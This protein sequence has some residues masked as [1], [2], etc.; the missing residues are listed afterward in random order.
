MLLP[1]NVG[2]PAAMV[3]QAMAVY[4]QLGGSRGPGG[5]KASEEQVGP[6][7]EAANRVSGA[8][9]AVASS[10]PARPDPEDDDPISETPLHSN[11]KLSKDEGF[12]L[13]QR[14]MA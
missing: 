14:A 4:K 12:S 7:A 1:A 8:E 2:D 3:A 10:A 9:D 5:L 6:Q 13:Q 11:I